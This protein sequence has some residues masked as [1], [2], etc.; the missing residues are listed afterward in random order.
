MMG[1]KRRLREA[2]RVQQ[3]HIAELEALVEYW[4]KLAASRMERIIR[5]RDVCVAG[6]PV[7]PVQ[8]AFERLAED[9]RVPMAGKPPP[10]W[11]RPSL[12]EFGTTKP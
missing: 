3:Q 2:V 1:E 12:G 7:P 9:R 10:L 5:I 8:R 4:R 6:L 11:G